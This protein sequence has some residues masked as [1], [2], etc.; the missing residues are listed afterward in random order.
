MPNPLIFVI[1]SREQ[2]PL[3]LEPSIRHKL[4]AGDY[5]V[6]GK[7]VRIAVERKS[8]ND[9]TGSITRGFKRFRRELILLSMMNDRLIGGNPGSAAVAIESSI[10]HLNAHCYQSTMR[11]EAVLAKIARLES[12]FN[13]PFVWCEDRAKC[14]EWVRNFLERAARFATDENR[15][16]QSDQNP[17]G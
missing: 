6:L 8:L 14:A 10:T 9:L 17:A 7:E 15:T 12:D 1:D 3:V 4:L 5:S 13:V 2:R 11:P 16:E